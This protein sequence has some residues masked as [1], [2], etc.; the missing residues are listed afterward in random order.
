M[1]QK[2]MPQQENTVVRYAAKIIPQKLI[3]VEV[4]ILL[5]VVSYAIMASGVQYFSLKYSC[6]HLYLF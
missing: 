5:H 1:G 4:V 3:I 2:V 6:G